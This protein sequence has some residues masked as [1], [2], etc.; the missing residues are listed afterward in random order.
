MTVLS[1]CKYG[2]DKPDDNTLRLTLIYTPGL[3]GGNGAEY[4]DQTTQDWGHHEFVYGLA[5]H[6]GDWRTEQSDWQ[7]LRLNQPLIALTTSQHPGA[8]GKAFSF[9]QVSSPRLRVLALKRAE[10]SQ[11]TIVRLVEMDG[12]SQSNAEI[13][14]AAP[15]VAAREVDGQEMPLRD[16]GVSHGALVTSF[17]PYQLRSFAVTLAPLLGGTPITQPRSQPVALPVNRIVAGR[18]GARIRNG[19]GFDA[20]GRALPAEM[21]PSTI[22]FAGIS[23]SLAASPDG[24][25]QALVP[26]GETISLPTGG[27]KR[28]YLLAASASGD[29]KATFRV[30]DNPIEL[31]IQDWSGFIGQWDDRTWS[32][33]KEPLPPRPD[34][35]GDESPRFRTVLEFTGLKPGFIK[36]SPVAWF[37]SHRHTAEGANEPY[38]YSYLFAYSINLPPDARAVTLPD[39]S[40]IRILAMTVSDES[41]ETGPA[42]PLYDT[43]ER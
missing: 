36:R 18:D 41:S 17:D 28:L 26:H 10:H 35:P 19:D 37:A 2:S 15:V 5:G 27:Y 31:T 13:K 40:R 7:A 24:I 20:D 21:L 3:G 9:M 16:A 43:L 42:Q 38:S 6:S 22:S 23:F 12:R 4:S 1:D 11:E 32:E 14:F 34:S 30:G 39:N 33:K 8:L 25:Q 29:Q